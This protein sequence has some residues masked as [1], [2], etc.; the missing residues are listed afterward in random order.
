MIGARYFGKGIQAST[1]TQEEIHS[2]EPKLSKFLFKSARDYSGHGT[3]TLSVA[4]GAFVGNISEMGNRI[5]TAKGGAPKAR[6]AAYK[7]LWDGY[8]GAE[9][10]VLA[11][12]DAAIYDGVDVITASL[13]GTFNEYFECSLSIGG[14]HAM[15]HGI[16]IIAAVGNYGPGEATA[17][18]T[19]PWLFSVGASTMDRDFY[20]YVTLGNKMVFK[21]LPLLFIYK[22]IYVL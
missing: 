2:D 13:G 4:A 15:K 9:A 16:P 17:G 6:V 21:V 3:S 18:N 1:H 7:T 10:D 5:G 22:Y 20:N 8:G 11:A 19:A 12:I 14:F